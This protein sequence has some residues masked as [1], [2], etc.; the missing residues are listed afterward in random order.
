MQSSAGSVVAVTSVQTVATSVRDLTGQGLTTSDRDQPA[1]VRT[2]ASNCAALNMRPGQLAAEEELIARELETWPERIARERARDAKLRRKAKADYKRD[3]KNARKV[4]R[5]LDRTE[6]GPA[7]PP[8]MPTPDH[9]ARRDRERK[10]WSNK[11]RKLA[12][13]RTMQAKALK[14]YNPKLAGRMFL[15]ERIGRE[16]TCVEC[17]S[18]GTVPVGCNVRGCPACESKKADKDA[19]KYGACFEGRR[20]RM[21]TFTQ[22]NVEIT[23]HVEND[24]AALRAALKKLAPWFRKIRQNPLFTVAL[25]GGIWKREVTVKTDGER[26]WWHV[27]LHVLYW[28]AYIRQP[29][30]SAAWQQLSGACIVDIRERDNVREVVKYACKAFDYEDNQSE[31]RAGK[32]QTF[33]QV[34]VATAG[35]IT[36]GFLL[37]L[38]QRASRRLR[39]IQTFGEAYAVPDPEDGDPQCPDCGGFHF[40][41]RRCVVP[42]LATGPP[43]VDLW[44]GADLYNPPQKVEP[45]I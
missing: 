12:Y 9:L 31:N 4:N 15:C 20:T 23:G 8:E 3:W 32:G 39:L 10:K 22:K 25:A 30:L 26:V 18:Q 40:Q 43:A 37:D 34:E 45:A 7:P 2:F 41:V 17:G 35:R 29:L 11:R 38:W 42:Y 21:I 19:A 5:E 16:Y 14:P 1:P 13:L 28:G 36:A 24:A 27:H 6:A 44:R 33:N